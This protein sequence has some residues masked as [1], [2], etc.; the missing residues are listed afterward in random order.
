MLKIKNIISTII[1]LSITSLLATACSDLDSHD[2]VY[3]FQK[4]EDNYRAAMRWGEWTTI[5]YM[6]RPGPESRLMRVDPADKSTYKVMETK[7]EVDDGEDLSAEQEITREDLIAH[8]E[9]IL[10]SHSEVTSSSVNNSKGTG[11]TRMNIQYHFDNSAIIKTLRYKLS[12]WHDKESNTWFTDTPLP[13][14][15]MPPK[16]KTIKLSP[17][18][19]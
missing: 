8:L 16:K 12:W 15:F 6:I 10:I 9:T 13:E 3:R 18:R 14:E 7:T 5:L 17:K 11:T 1:V 4:S 2:V 19:Y